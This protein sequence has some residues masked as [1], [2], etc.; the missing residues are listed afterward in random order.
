LVFVTPCT[1][2]LAGT[3]IDARCVA[4][5]VPYHVTRRGANGQ[6][7]LFTD[8]DRK[9]GVKLLASNSH[10]SGVG[11]LAWCLMSNHIQLVA[12]SEAGDSLAVLLRRAHGRYARC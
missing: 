9:T 4:P 3:P 5:A 8:S 10:E 7:L 11:V 2:D 1:R 6:R 12:V